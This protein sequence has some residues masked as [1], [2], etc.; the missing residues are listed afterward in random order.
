MGGLA[1]WEISLFSPSS[2]L[3][4]TELPS[5]NSTVSE[6]PRFVPPE[7][8]LRHSPGK[9]NV[10][11]VSSKFIPAASFPGEF[12]TISGDISL[13]PSLSLLL[14]R[15]S[16]MIILDQLRNRV[17]WPSIYIIWWRGIA[18]F[19]I[20]IATVLLTRVLQR[21]AWLVRVTVILYDGKRVS[22]ILSAFKFG[23]SWVPTLS[24]HWEKFL[25]P[26]GTTHTWYPIGDPSRSN[27]FWNG[28]NFREK[29]RR[30][31][32]FGCRERKGIN[33]NRLKYVWMIEIA[34]E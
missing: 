12:P 30:E 26:A 13:F 28:L 11:F 27:V 4:S 5:F 29:K 22:M 23:P 14:G 15:L 21:A 18:L 9:P 7:L 16:R 33:L 3:S 8:W 25:M 19:Q 1:V 31:R 17:W 2:Q 6:N 32:V 10:S 20:S 34:D 24:L